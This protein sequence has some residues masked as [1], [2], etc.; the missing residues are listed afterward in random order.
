MKRS[1]ITTGD[2]STTIRLEEWQEHYHSSHGA[3]NEARHVFIENGLKCFQNRKI[4]I[5]EIGFGTG[6]NAFITYLESPKLGLSICYEGVEAYPVE[7][8][9]LSELNYISQLDAEAHKDIFKQMHQVSWDKEVVI[10]PHFSLNKRKQQFEQIS[11]DSRFHLIYYDAFG[12]RVQPELWTE[13]VFKKMYEALCPGGCLV[14]YSSK[15]SARRAM[16]AVGFRV[17]KLY[18]PPGKRE[19]LRA[20]KE[21]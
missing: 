13:S 9:E 14:T 12:A 20:W 5:L 3:V 16:L 7:K 21:E 1:I 18:G 15:S 11:D 2:G 6:L 8:D 10:A 19:M 4:A 17:E